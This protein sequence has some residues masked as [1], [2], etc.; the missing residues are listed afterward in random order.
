M[1]LFEKKKKNNGEREYYIC[2]V[3]IFKYKRKTLTDSVRKLGVKT[4]ENVCF[5][6][7]PNLG[8]EPY[9]IEIGN[10]V[11]IS[12]EVA[13]LTHDGSIF[14]CQNFCKDEITKF[15]KIKIGNNCFIGCRSTILPNITIGDNSIVGACSVVTK[16]I[17]EGEVWAGNPA[18]FI[19]KTIDLAKKFEIKS[20]EQELID[21]YEYVK[22]KRKKR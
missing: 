21:L 5:V 13:F 12:Y 14:V 11:L 4:G 16:S 20:K 18:K 9:L 6:S 7:M 1:K 15:G 8:S 2:G 22:E 3:K 17:P 19:C 10:D